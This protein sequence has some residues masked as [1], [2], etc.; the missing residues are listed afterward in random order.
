VREFLETSA[1]PEQVAFVCFDAT[2][3]EPTS[4]RDMSFRTERGDV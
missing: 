3:C 2:T 1:L 4:G